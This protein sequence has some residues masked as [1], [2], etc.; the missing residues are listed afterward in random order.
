MSVKEIRGE[1]VGAIIIISVLVMCV[2]TWLN[3]I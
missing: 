1:V 2:S 3:S